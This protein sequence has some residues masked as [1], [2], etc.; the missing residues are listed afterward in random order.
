MYLSKPAYYADFVVYPALLVPLAAEVLWGRTVQ[1][2]IVWTL[3]C[4]AGVLAFSLIEYCV[5]RF[6]LHH[7]S[8]L[9]EMHAEHHDHP[10]A[11]VG[12][13]TWATVA[14]VAVLVFLPLWWQAGLNVACG[15]SFGLI[16]SYL[17]YG[18]LHHAIHHWP[19][20]KGSYLH[21]AKRWHGKHHQARQYCN[22]GVTTAFWDHVF[23][24][25]RRG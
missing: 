15:L 19:T 11:L 20:R 8:P 3:A 14:L 21:W 24:T 5:H 12:T 1:A 13:P 17:A 6:L 4:M 16:V 22:F 2:E 9:R 10:A 23:G 7:V 18:L 25:V